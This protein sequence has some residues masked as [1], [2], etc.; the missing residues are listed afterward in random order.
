VY[1]KTRNV[2]MMYCTGFHHRRIKPHFS[3]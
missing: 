3:K 2:R 1:L